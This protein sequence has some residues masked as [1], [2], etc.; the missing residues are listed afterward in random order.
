MNK[1]YQIVTDQIMQ[2]LRSGRIPWKRSWKSNSPQ[3]MTT[4]KAYRGMNNL[5]LGFLPYKF[6]FYVTFNQCKAMGYMVNK[7]EH[8]HIVT[9]WKK[10]TGEDD[11]TGDTKSYAILRYYT[12]FNVEQT[13]IPASEY[14]KMEMLNF[15]PNEKAESI[16]SNMPNSPKVEHKGNRA[17]YSPLLD[18]VTMPNRETFDSVPEYYTVLFH[19]LGHSTGH[20][21]RLNRNLGAGT[22][23][24]E[25]YSFE[26]LVAELT[27]CFVATESGLDVTIKN[28][29]AYIQS[30][31]GKLEENPEWI[32]KAA[33]KAQKA[34][35][36]ILGRIENE[37]VEEPI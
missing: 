22:F 15:A 18:T 30:W 21:K 3:N 9:F 23:G 26:E 28:S 36:Y 20:D 35:D 27:S 12:V 11:V 31:L 7:G 4:K 32:I 17:C 6:P 19:E 25:S 14:P 33:G 16:I 13:T 5:L 2:E 37:K 8:G 1:V 29:A 24:N 10:T 34:A